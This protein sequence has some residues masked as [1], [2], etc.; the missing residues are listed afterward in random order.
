MKKC[1]LFAMFVLAAVPAMAQSDPQ[2]PHPPQDPSA[3]VAR[4]PV[5]SWTALPT[6][7]P[8]VAAEDLPKAVQRPPAAESGGNVFG[9][10]VMAMLMANPHTQYQDP[11]PPCMVCGPIL[12]PGGVGPVCQPGTTKQESGYCTDINGNSC[13]YFQFQADYIC[14]GGFWE[15]LYYSAPASCNGGMTAPC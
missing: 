4:N 10:A 2:M 7:S 11:P 8:E 15:L 14:Q 13:S 6:E 9:L 3:D 1:I 5:A 12:P